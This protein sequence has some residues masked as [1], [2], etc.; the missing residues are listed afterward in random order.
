M[1]FNGSKVT[2]TVSNVGTSDSDSYKCVAENEAG[3]D[4]IKANVSV[5]GEGELSD[6]FISGGSCD[7]IVKN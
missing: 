3:Q 1:E 5:I 2:L 7:F 4:Q 6:W